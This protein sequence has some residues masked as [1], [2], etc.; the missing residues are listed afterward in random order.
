MRVIM[1]FLTAGLAGQGASQASDFPTISDHV[2]S[3]FQTE[4]SVSKTLGIT[5]YTLRSLETLALDIIKDFES[6]VPTPYNDASMYCTLGYGHLLTKRPCANSSA[7]IALLAPPPPLRVSDGVTLL[8]ADTGAVRLAVSRLVKRPLSDEQFGS[9][10]SFVFNVG[11][12]N[13]SKSTMLRYLNNGEDEGAAREFRRWIGSKGQILDGLITRRACEAALFRK[14]LKYRSDGT[15][16][17]S[18]C[19]SLGA[20]SSSG[21]VIYIETGEK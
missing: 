18:D 13:F 10:T 21:S 3:V 8:N 17:R 15:F 12:Y 4:A 9:L 1:F 19:K 14:Q 20:A 2:T 6:W 11:A 5:N 7:E 16:N